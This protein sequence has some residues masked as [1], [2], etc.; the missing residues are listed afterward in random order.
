MVSLD[1]IYTFYNKFKYYFL[2]FKLAFAL[3]YMAE[4]NSKEAI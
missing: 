4:S 1:K 3:F 2:A